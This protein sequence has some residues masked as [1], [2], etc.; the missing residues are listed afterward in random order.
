MPIADSKR[1]RRSLDLMDRFTR[2]HDWMRDNFYSEWEDVYQQYTCTPEDDFDSNQENLNKR[3]PNLFQ[4]N[5]DPYRKDRTNG[6]RDPDVAIK[7]MQPD[8][9]GLIRRKVARATGSIPNLNFK[10]TDPALGK[11]VARTIMMQWDKSGHQRRQKRHVTIAFLFGISVKLWYWERQTYSSYIRVNPM[12]AT[13]DQLGMIA[14]QYAPD[15]TRI[16][17]SLTSQMGLFDGADGRGVEELSQEALAQ[18]LAEKG[19]GEYLRLSIDKQGYIG[20]RC[21]II[22]PWDFFPEPDY[23]YLDEA[24]WVCITRRRRKEWFTS[25]SAYYSSDQYQ[26]PGDSDY[27]FHSDE[28]ERLIKDMPR[29]GSQ[30]HNRRG[31][32]LRHRLESV[33]GMLTDS[34][35]QDSSEEDAEYEV[36]EFHYPGKGCVEYLAEGGYYLGKVKYPF[37]LE[38]N[39]VPLTDLVF[40]DNILHGIGD[41]SSRR[42][43]DLV[44]THSLHNSL[45]YD[46]VKQVL[47]PYYY[48]TDRRFFENPE[49]TD[50][51]KGFRLLY[52]S[53]PNEL[54]SVHESAALASIASSMGDESSIQRSIQYGTGETNMSMSADLDPAQNRTAT[55]AKIVQ[56]NQDILSREEQLMLHLSLYSDL[57]MMR[58]MNKSE[59]VDTIAFN[60]EPYERRVAGENTAAVTGISGS[61][62]PP[63]EWLSVTPDDF[64]QEGQIYPE[65][66]STLAD[67]DDDKVNRAVML[68]EQAKATPHLLNVETARD[69]FLIAMGEG[70]NLDKWTPVPPPEPPP[71]PPQERAQYNFSIRMEDLTPEQQQAVLLKAMGEPPPPQ[72]QPPPAPETI[73]DMTED[74]MMAMA[75]E[76]AGMGNGMGGQV[77]Y[78]E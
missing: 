76:S 69:N 39:G 9:W 18:L 43:K 8:Q 11:R 62:Q 19:K 52:L 42:I 77:P 75:M 58:Q 15:I 1:D 59:L 22:G 63:P 23:Q 67:D 78:G 57:E 36:M 70:R 14:E 46:A 71:V 31:D 49:L 16:T 56:A 54:N 60:S 72:E 6:R 20:P 21:D 5:G 32:G 3:K 27:T 73:P 44:W 66:G 64:Q 12:T 45:R 13:D 7:V 47:R 25:M 34:S 41:S 74:Q 4:A 51:G 29:G 26:Y 40:V 33:A 38:N 50:R 68:Y 35:Y 2:S 30:E 61:P 65:V 37:E 55:G 28:A 53:G 48:T 10:S 17:Q 24:N